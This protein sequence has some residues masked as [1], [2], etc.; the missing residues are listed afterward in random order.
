[1]G[2]KFDYI[3]GALRLKDTSKGGVTPAELDAEIAARVAEDNTLQSNIDAVNSLVTEIETDLGEEIIAR[4][5]A[6][7]TLQGNIDTLTSVT[8]E[9]EI[10]LG[11]LQTNIDNEASTR[12]SA[13][14]SL[15]SRASILENNVLKVL[16]FAT[17][18]TASGTITKPTGST[19]ILNDFPSALDAVVETLVSGEPSGLTPTTAGGAAISVTS[20]DTSGNYVLSGIPTGNIAF[21]YVL[22]IPDIYRGNLTFDNIIEAQRTNLASI[23][24]VDAKIIDSI[25]D[26]DTDHAPSRNAVFDALALKAD[27]VSITGA[28]K[29]KITYNAQGIV[30]AGT[31]ATTVDIADTTNKRYQTD[32]QQSFNDATSSIQTQLNAK[33]SLD[34]DLTTIAA[35]NANTGSGVLAS[36]GS[37][38]IYKTYSALKTA[39]D[40]TKSD[41]GLSSVDNT[42]DVNKPVSTAQATADAAVLVS[43]NS[44][45]DSLVVGLLDDRGNFDASGNVFP[46]SGGS[47]SAGAIKKGDLWSISVAG[48]LGG[49]AV[50]IGDVIRALS[51]TPGQT[52][53]NW[54]ITE[55]NFGYVAENT[56]N[57]T[58]T[59]TGNESSTTLYSNIKGVVD[60]V[61]QGLTGVLS[62]KTTPVDAD[63]VI[64][65]DSADSS[66]TKTVTYTNVKAF[67]KTY[68]DGIYQ[69]G[70]G[71]TAENIANK[72]TDSTFA[73]NSDTKYPSQKAVKTALA[74]KMDK[75]IPTAV[76]TGSYTAVV[77]DFIP[78]DA[79]AATRVITLPTAPTD[80]SIIAIKMIAVSGSFVT[81]INTGGSDVFNK[82]GGGTSLNL[83][84]VNQA[85]LLQYKS[86]SAIWYVL[87]DDLSLSTLDTRY[88]NG[89][90][91]TDGTLAA[92]SDTKVA[93]Q[94][95]T[96]TYADTKQTALGFTPEN[97]V[98]KDATGG[99]VGL[100]LFKINFKNAL[101]T[102]TS[103]LTNANTVAR[104]YIFQ[105]RN[106]TIADD[107][108]LAL[109]ENLSNKVTD[110]TVVNNTVYPT[111]QAV[112]NE[113]LSQLATLSS[114]AD[115]QYASAVALPANTYNNG[116]S[117]VGATLTG[118]SNGPLL[119][120][121]VT[122]LVAQ[123][124]QKV[125]VTAEATSAN[126]GWYTITQ[127]GVI[128]ISPYIL[129][130]DT[131]SDTAAEIGA[132]YL[133]GVV[134]NNSFTAGTNNGKV[135]I[136]IAVDPFTVG[137]TALTFSQ[138]GGTYTNGNGISL[139]G[140]TF[141][142]DLTVVVDKTTAQTLTNK[143]LTA[144]VINSPTG[145][146]KGDVGL[147]NV[148]NALQLIAA[149]NLSDLVSAKTARVNIGIETRTTHGD[150]DY[151]ILLS[152]KYLVTS[153]TL[154]APRVWTLPA[155]STFN[156]GQEINIE[157]EFGGVTSTNTITITRG[158]SDTINGGT[159][160][161]INSAYGARRLFSD[162]VSKWSFNGAEVFLAKTQTLTNKSIDGNNNTFSN[163]VYT[164]FKT[165][166]GNATKYD[167]Y[168]VNGAPSLFGNTDSFQV[169]FNGF[170]G[171]ATANAFALNPKF[172]CGATIVGWTIEGDNDSGS[173]VV[174][175][176][177]WGGAAY[178]SII[179][180]GNKPT[181]SSGRQATAVQ[182]GSWTSITLAT[183]D[184]LKAVLSS[185]SVFTHVVVTFYYNITS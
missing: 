117:G 52:D 71:Y 106:G 20:L 84:L 110:F 144:P 19:I 47:G 37:G 30:T 162:G 39:L 11:E 80:Q 102:I 101:N 40:L 41:V 124:G 159:T 165:V 140:S 29:T 135:Y 88:V 78:V 100:T 160:E 48:T 131:L 180:S 163:I 170:G 12:A 120:D 58:S 142:I 157:D 64:I 66:K 17:I 25:A 152:D 69:A 161:I 50:T 143:T 70:L 147:G 77:D 181:I 7:S 35:I 132:G 168:D 99:Y 121:G 79:T 8:N 123:A 95:A 174:D 36:D 114:K 116:S 57:K 53:S 136:S 122:I 151:T 65:S 149:N 96:K 119:I 26:A 28:T 145:I 34:S 184:R 92:N 182:N 33:Q 59:I 16:Y 118:N 169:T 86:S 76:K 177:R 154:T 126:N 56:A 85:M 10:D 94:K 43:A 1:M 134:A 127:V 107:T 129:T 22:S 130:R 176:Q 60:W 82:S 72:D 83:T 73:A 125:L 108:D 62:S 21:L 98:N 153:A 91:D 32:N 164:N 74:L 45:S 23:G 133:T 156:P 61:K 115:V 75:L 146:V 173:S 128:T 97:S 27:K 90:L 49:H 4:A 172:K 14:N 171:V 13:D 3:L 139:T 158:G 150:S 55:N 179:G 42:S 67:L 51:D 81:T 178:T 137:T 9:I 112:R 44:Y 38:W 31:D 141:S 175:L 166:I 2:V 63:S 68:F 5:N 54:N 104:T 113:I 138:V 46:S 18:N 24:Y 167:G 103:F 155:A 15:S 185:N 105:D 183:S 148:S 111:T 109:K 6:D 93:S 89:V 87:S